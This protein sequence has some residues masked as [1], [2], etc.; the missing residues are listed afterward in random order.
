KWSE[1]S[2]NSPMWT[3]MPAN[4]L[5]KCAEALALRKAFP[6]QLSGLYTPDEMEQARTPEPVVVVA[7]PARISLPEG[8][9]QIVTAKV[10]AYGGDVTVVDPNG[11]ETEHKTT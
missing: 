3:K 8:T 1:Y 5:A 9:F 7:P 4:Q 11:V 10:T 6:H 2:Q